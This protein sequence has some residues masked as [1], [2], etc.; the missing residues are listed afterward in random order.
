MIVAIVLAG[1]VACSDWLEG[2]ADKMTVSD[3]IRRIDT[4]V[5]GNAPQIGDLLNPPATEAH[6]REVEL[7]LNVVFPES[8]RRAYLWRNGEARD[9][10]GVF[11]MLRFLPIDEIA[12]RRRMFLASDPRTRP[13]DGEVRKFIPFLESGGG[14][15]YYVMSASDEN[16]EPAVREWWHEQPYQAPIV[17]ESFGD[18]LR[19]FAEGL[20][21]GDLVFLGNGTRGLVRRDEI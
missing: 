6:I 13:D 5:S 18:F 7:E 15:L 9:S 2:P 20:E 19:D 4:W 1:G 12:E 10:H 17:H 21:A 11:G 14:D 16:P 8:L 3:S